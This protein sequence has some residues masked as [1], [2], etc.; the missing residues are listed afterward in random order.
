MSSVHLDDVQIEDAFDDLPPLSLRQSYLGGALRPGQRLGRLMLWHACPPALRHAIAA[1]KPLVL[2]IE[3]PGADWSEYIYEAALKLVRPAEFLSRDRAGKS[4]GFDTQDTSLCSAVAV[5]HSLVVVSSSGLD[6]VSEA[7]QASLDYHVK[8]PRPGCALIGQTIKATFRTRAIKPLPAELGLDLSAAKLLGAIRTGESAAR[9][10]S[11]LI[12][13]ARQEQ[14][15]GPSGPGPLLEELGGYGQAK[16]WGL[17]L[18]RDIEAYRRG[19]LGWAE[20]SSAAVLYGEPGTGKTYFAAALARSCRMPLVATA[21]GEIF[22]ISSGYLD[23][24]CKGLS[25]AFKDARDKRPALLFFDELDSIP[26]RRSLDPRGREWWSTVVNH[27]L[28]LIDN[29]PDGIVLLGATNLIDRLDSALIRPGR[30]EKHFEITAPGAAELV[31]MFRVQLGAHLPDADLAAIARLAAGSSGARVAMTVKSA[32]AAA[33]REGREVMLDDVR[34]ELAGEETAPD[35][36]WRICVHE[37]GHAVAAL[38]FGREVDH[39]TTLVQGSHRPMTLME[40]PGPV[41]TRRRLE[42][43]SVIFLAGRCAE[44]LLL[45]EASIGAHKDLAAVTSYVAAIHGSFGLGDS[46][47]HRIAH[48]DVS[49]LLVDPS[50]RKTIGNDLHSLEARCLELLSARLAQVRAVAEALQAK[51]VLTGEELAA[52]VAA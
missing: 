35:L 17:D 9:A 19:D 20:I 32:I 46:L 12:E 41:A 15:I 27:M 8:I 28:K 42:E 5:A 37:A 11:R 51:R 24:V 29:R 16:G 48:T 7:I 23:G 40:G 33:R 36:L 14:P 18:A 25:A 43:Q 47:V 4:K 49:A 26:D 22:E 21:L 31:K 38:T 30:L 45:G 44:I 3:P 1:R 2:L 50:F 52:L 6:G 34:R 10:V 39:V 13:L